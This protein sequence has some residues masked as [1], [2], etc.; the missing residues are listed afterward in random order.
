MRSAKPRANRVASHSSDMH[1]KSSRMG[2]PTYGLDVVALA[3]AVVLAA[4]LVLLISHLMP[5]LADVMP[6]V[7]S[8]I[9]DDSSSARTR[10]LSC[11]GMNRNCVQQS[12]FQM[13]CRCHSEGLGFDRAV[14]DLQAISRPAGKRSLGRL[15]HATAC[16]AAKIKCL[17]D[18]NRTR[19]G[20]KATNKRLH[21]RHPP[22]V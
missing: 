3:L 10:R 21:P 19:T 22:L 9:P 12:R 11:V 17:A 7:L 4:A 2:S 18:S 20:N 1:L 14:T 6:P 5:L 8:E 15:M 16:L 13:G